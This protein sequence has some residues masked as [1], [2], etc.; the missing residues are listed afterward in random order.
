MRRFVSPMS[1][2]S[3]FVRLLSGIVVAIAIAMTTLS[4][5][6]PGRN[7]NMV[8]GTKWPDGD[9]FLQRQNE[10]SIAASTRNPLHLFAGAKLTALP[11][12]LFI[13]DNTANWNTPF[14]NE[15]AALVSTV[16]GLNDN[17]NVGLMMF[18]ETGGG[19]GNPDGGYVKFAVRQ[20]T[21]ANKA[22]LTASSYARIR[23]KAARPL[24]WGR[25]KPSAPCRGSSST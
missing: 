23:P 20:M 2:H 4:A 5:Q 13:V 24:A 9:P 16:L 21:T 25:S 17:Y 7:V 1:N 19:N 22:V 18:T 15:K 11:N 6:I 14:D 3:S 8:A 12:V 10:P